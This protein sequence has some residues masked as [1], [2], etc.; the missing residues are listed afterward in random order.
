ME[1]ETFYFE[2]ENEGFVRGGTKMEN[3]SKAIRIL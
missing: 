2:G 1:S 3:W